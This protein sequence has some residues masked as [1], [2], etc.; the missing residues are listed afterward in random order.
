MWAAAFVAAG[1]EMPVLLLSWGDGRTGSA[2]GLQLK[3]RKK[4]HSLDPVHLCHPKKWGCIG[5]RA[6]APVVAVVWLSASGLPV[7][8]VDQKKK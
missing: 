8:I 6:V 4:I 2:R 5:S 3:G 1:P 7:K